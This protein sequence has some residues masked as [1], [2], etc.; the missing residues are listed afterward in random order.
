MRLQAPAASIVYMSKRDPFLEFVE[1]Q[2][3]QRMRFSKK[4]ARCWLT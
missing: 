2:V 3:Y 1:E 4:V